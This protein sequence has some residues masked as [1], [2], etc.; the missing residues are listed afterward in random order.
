MIFFYIIG[1]LIFSHTILLRVFICFKRRS[2]IDLKRVKIELIRKNDG[3]KRLWPILSAHRGGSIE[4]TEN[5]LVAF[6]NAINQGTN[7][8]ECDVHLSKDGIVVIAHDTDLL[9]ICGIP[10]RNVK[11]YDFKDLPQI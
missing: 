11:D 4:R 8:L 2:R 6:K 3:R 1:W 10:D 5:T 7:L 9:R